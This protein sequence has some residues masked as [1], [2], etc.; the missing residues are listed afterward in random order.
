MI[1]LRIKLLGPADET[2]VKVRVATFP[3]VVSVPASPV[4]LLTAVEAPEFKVKPAG[5]VTSTFPPFGMALVVVKA[6]VTLLTAPAFKEAGTTDAK[7]MAPA[8]MV[9]PAT[10]RF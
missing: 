10:D 5:K 8:V 1:L 9:T 6:T 2:A 3:A 4:K 7:V